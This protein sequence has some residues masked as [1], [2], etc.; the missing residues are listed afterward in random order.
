MAVGGNGVGNGV[1]D[2]VGERLRVGTSV[3]VEVGKVAGP[4]PSSG[5]NGVASGG[6]ML[7]GRESRKVE[8]TMLRGGTDDTLQPASSHRQPANTRGNRLLMKNAIRFLAGR[9]RPGAPISTAT[10]VSYQ[11]ENWGEP[12]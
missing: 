5:S 10:A 6:G 12:V 9:V 4:S 3:A 1:G 2:E 7:N 8:S 11:G